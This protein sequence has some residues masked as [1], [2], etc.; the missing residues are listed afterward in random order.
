MKKSSLSKTI[1]YI[2]IPIFLLA[3]VL[4]ICSII[5]QNDDSFDENKYYSSSRFVSSYMN[6]I[7]NACR[8]LIYDNAN[9][10]SIEDGDNTIYFINTNSEDYYSNVKEWKYLIVYKNK[11][12]TNVELNN[13]TKTIDGIKNVLSQQTNSQKVNI[14]KGEF[15]ADNEI[16]QK[17]GIQYLDSLKNEYYTVPNDEEI[18]L[19]GESNIEYITTKYSDFEIY[20]NY[21]EGFKE[22]SQEAILL[23]ILNSVSLVTDNSYIIIP[24]CSVLTLLMI[25]YLILSIGSDKKLNDFDHIPFEIIIVLSVI[26]SIVPFIIREGFLNLD[27]YVDISIITTTYLLTYTV[28]MVCLTTLIRRLKAKSFWKTTLLGKIYFWVTKILKKIIS[29]LTYSTNM[30]V[31]VIIY[32]G[33]MAIIAFCI[34]L[35][36]GFSLLAMVLEFIL[37]LNVL[38]KITK[39]LKSFSKIESRLKEMKEGNNQVPLDVNEFEPELRNMAIYLNQVSEGIEKAIQDRMKSERLKAELITNVS[40]DIKTPLTS[41]I[42][43]VDLLKKEPIEN[44][45][46]KEY[47]EILDSKSQRLKNLTEDLIE[48]SKVSTG[49]ISLRIEKINIVE[50]VRQAIGEFEDRFQKKGLNTILDTSEN[51]IYIMADSK[52]MYR[53]IENLFSNIA[54]YALENSRVYVDLKKIE[55]KVKLEIKNISKDKLNISSDEL[56]QRFVRGDKSRTTEGSGLGIS[57]AQNLTELQHGKFNLILDGDLFKVKLEF[58]LA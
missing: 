27:F 20:T 58:E 17:T 34:L 53:I 33:V 8:N 10:Y 54:K 7:S 32:G 19:D 38:Y 30:T 11:A 28:I 3:I 48:A 14:I 56:M 21:I 23:N 12:L 37:L 42:N 52:Y 43:Y 15:Q 44:E 1:C 49:N 55:K 51:E 18:T 50:L 9:Y 47:I 2:F 22:N 4:S 29:N 5:I 36:F 31:K 16:I 6:D 57:I 46:A 41:I 26:I 45:K 24:I 39:F 40:H 25:I 35:L 13:N